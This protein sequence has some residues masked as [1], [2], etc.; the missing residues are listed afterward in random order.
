MYSIPST[1]SKKVSS[2]K[3]N[4]QDNYDRKVG[5]K[6]KISLKTS[7]I[8]DF[9]QIWIRKFWGSAFTPLNLRSFKQ[10]WMFKIHTRFKLPSKEEYCIRPFC[11]KDS[12][13]Y[14][15]IPNCDFPPKL[16]A[17]TKWV[18]IQILIQMIERVPKNWLLIV[19][20]PDCFRCSVP[21]LYWSWPPVPILMIRDHWLTWEVPDS[22]GRQLFIC[23]KIV[24][25]STCQWKSLEISLF[26]FNFPNI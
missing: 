1:W 12:D 22:S 7:K 6:Q 25:K 17:T 15:S 3:Q 5:E 14:S 4:K 20:F 23:H 21:K 11:M 24:K 18:K 19:W 8:S 10:N 9:V 13:C 2:K 26:P 16:L